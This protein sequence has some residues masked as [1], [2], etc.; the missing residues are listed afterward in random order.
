MALTTLAA[1]V[2]RVL[3]VDHTYLFSPAVRRIK[4]LIEGGELGE[5]YYVDSVRINL[6]LFQHDVNVIWDL[7]VHDVSI[8]QYLFGKRPTAVSAVGMGHVKGQT[9][10]VAYVTLMYG[11]EPLLV[12]LHVNWLA[13]VKIRQ[14]LIG[15]TKQMVV[16]DDV[17]ASE[18]VKVYDKGVELETAPERVH[19]LRVGY[20]SGDM[21]APRIDGTEALRVMAQ[22]FAECVEQGKRPLTD[23]EAGLGIVQALEAATSSMQHRGR[24]TK[25]GVN[26]PL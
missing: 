9:E 5:L 10:N 24:P 17:E 3:M 11:D 21:F 19:Q 14:T 18:K 2:G 12:H 6:G 15:G 16:Y 7:A 8:V 22:H 1:R 26:E 13:P 20:R 23:G 4:E 25:I